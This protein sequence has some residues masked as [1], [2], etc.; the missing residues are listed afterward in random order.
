MEKYEHLYNK[1]VKDLHHI[2]GKSIAQQL[3]D[4]NSSSESSYIL[5]T[6][7]LVGLMIFLYRY[8]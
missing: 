2:Q 6:I 8:L 3:I 4:R 7:F 1:L 5:I